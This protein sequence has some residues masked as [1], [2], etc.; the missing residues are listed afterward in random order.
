MVGCDEPFGAGD[1]EAGSRLILLFLKMMDLEV[2]CCSK[3]GRLEFAGDDAMAAAF[4]RGLGG[5]RV[6]LG[7]CGDGDRGNEVSPWPGEA[8]GAGDETSA[9]RLS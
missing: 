1:D 7:A 8:A 6:G 3:A 2:S 4:F 9:R 5:L